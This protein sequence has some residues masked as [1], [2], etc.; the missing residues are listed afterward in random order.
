MVPVHS[1]KDLKKGTFLALIK[2][3]GIDKNDL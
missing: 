1:G 2:Q 3:A